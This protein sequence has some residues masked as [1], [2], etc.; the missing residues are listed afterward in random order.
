MTARPIDPECWGK[1]MYAAVVLVL[2]LAAGCMG[3]SDTTPVSPAVPTH[4]IALSDKDRAE[5]TVT[6]AE[7]MIQ[8]ADRVIA[9]F[10]GNASTRDDYQLPAIVT[11]REAANS[12]LSSA[13]DEIR[14]GNYA[15]AQDKAEEALQKA[16]ESYNDA[17][18]RQGSIYSRYP[19]CERKL[20][21][22]KTICILL[23][24]LVPVLLTALVYSLIQTSPA[25]GMGRLRRFMGTGTGFILFIGVSVLFTA[26]VIGAKVAY[27]GALRQWMYIALVPW[28]C[29]MLVLTILSVAVIGCEVFPLVRSIVSRKPETADTEW[30]DLRLPVEKTRRVVK[31]IVTILLILTIPQVLYLGLSLAYP[32]LC[33]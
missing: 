17:L 9:W 20:P 3:Q 8:D 26:L 25:A 10:K 14:N 12:Y 32:V 6:D 22:D 29:M 33:M 15:Q 1:L 18:K 19:P 4:T 21:F 2:V 27:I 13:E 30:E 28:V 23:I 16:N 11:K 5:H 31:I 7:R 24:G